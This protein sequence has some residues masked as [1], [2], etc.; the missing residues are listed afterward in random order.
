[1]NTKNDGRKQTI[2][3]LLVRLELWLAPVL[4]VVPF[5]VSLFFIWDWYTR[6]FSLGFSAYDGELFLGLLLLIGNLTFDIPFLTS[7]RT[8]RKKF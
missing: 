4:I 7:V 8:Q 2:Q 3:N 5:G 6:G 1:M